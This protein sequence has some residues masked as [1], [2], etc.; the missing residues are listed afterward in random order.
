MRGGEREN[1]RD[2]ERY[3]KGQCTVV[4][5][6]KPYSH[7]RSGHQP[8]QIHEND[9]KQRG[10]A[11]FNER[12]KQGVEIEKNSYTIFAD[13]LPVD[14]TKKWLWRVFSS[15]GRVID[16]FLSRRVRA[17]NPLKF[18]FIRLANTGGSQEDGVHE[19]SDDIRHCSKHGGGT[20][21]RQTLKSLPGSE[22]LVHWTQVD[23]N[24]DPID[25]GSSS[26]SAPPGFDRIEQ[27]ESESSHS[28]REREEERVEKCV[29][30]HG[31]KGRRKTVIRL[32]DQLKEKARK[33]KEV[34]RQKRH[35]L[36]KIREE[37]KEEN[38]PMYEDDIEISE[39]DIEEIWRVGVK[40]GLGT[41]SE[42]RA[43]KYL[44]SKSKETN[45]N[46]KEGRKRRAR[47]R[48]RYSSEVGVSQNCS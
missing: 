16:I 22:M 13:N 47:S 32:N 37:E 4:S 45:D 38:W 44:I 10:G 15:T 48:K 7:W 36:R 41:D 25:S 43:K 14:S 40:T 34:H 19:N 17:R 21:V 29:N 26:L 39:D 6:R 20:L 46:R 35:K 31:G 28:E 1:Q 8:N 23:T 33:K 2:D 24:G 18:S 12:S 42:E 9:T 11:S 3:T 5:R 30:H 27:S